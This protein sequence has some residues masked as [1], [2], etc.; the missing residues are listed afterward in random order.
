MS[1]PVETQLHNI[2]ARTGMTV[3]DYARALAPHGDLSHGRM[4]AILKS[5]HGLTHGNANLIAHRVRDLAAGGPPPEDA[6]LAAQYRGDKAALRPVLDRI[7][8]VARDLGPDVQVVVQKT[9]VSLRRRK[10]LGVVGAPSGGR[11][12]LGLNLSATPPDPRVAEVTGMCSHQVELRTVDEVD[13]E[14]V[15]WIGA[16]YERAG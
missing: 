14:V 12:R 11:I 13:A 6:L 10:Q 4:L 16:A 2:T 5:E 7:V 8:E 15:A 9:G 3:E 1:D